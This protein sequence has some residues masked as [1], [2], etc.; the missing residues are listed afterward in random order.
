MALRLLVL[1]LCM[2]PLITVAS[3]EFKCS[4]MITVGFQFVDGEWIA[5]R[6]FERPFNFVVRRQDSDSE[7]TEPTWVWGYDDVGG[8]GGVCDTLPL[9]SNILSCFANDMQLDLNLDTLRFQHYSSA[10]YVYGDPKP[11][12]APT[13]SLG[14]CEK[15]RD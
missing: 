8:L 13:L 15:L 2:F 7:D 5:S 4:L 12:M 3:E 11:G 1:M 9:K 6:S 14:T 10:G